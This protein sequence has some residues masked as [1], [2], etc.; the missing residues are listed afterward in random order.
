MDL[1]Q[2]NNNRLTH[3]TYSEITSCFSSLINP[4]FKLVQ[5]TGTPLLNQAND[6][7]VLF[8]INLDL[9]WK[10]LNEHIFFFFEALAHLFCFELNKIVFFF[11]FHFNK[12]DD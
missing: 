11:F 2:S 10:L 12:F 5:L 3:H 9:L 1:Y 4:L 6:P 7:G 8:A